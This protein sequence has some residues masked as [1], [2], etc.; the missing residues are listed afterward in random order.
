M[1]L[2]IWL[3]ALVR[4]HVA[5]QAHGR[6]GP[7]SIQPLL[8]LQAAGIAIVQIIFVFFLFHLIRF[9][10]LVLDIS[11]WRGRRRKHSVEGQPSVLGG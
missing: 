7:G 1:L 9:L 10:V 6:A 8:L 4:H 5:H 2:R 3:C 11:G